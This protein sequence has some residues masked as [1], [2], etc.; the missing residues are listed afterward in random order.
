MV[1]GGV[2]RPQEGGGAGGYWDYPTGSDSAPNNQLTSPD[3]GNNANFWL[4]DGNPEY[5]IGG[6]YWMTEVGEFE[7]SESPY[8][9]FDQ[10]GNIWEW[11]E[12]VI[13]SEYA[14]R[15][16]RGGSWYSGSEYSLASGRYYDNPTDVYG[17]RVASVPEPGS[18]TLMLC[19]AIASLLWR[20]RRT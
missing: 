8:G 16:V 1:Q 15:G 14:G 9:T 12:T 10:G 19:G 5:T 20:R 4:P 13:V 11:N 18:I 17:F 6:P 2:L 7:N 3:P